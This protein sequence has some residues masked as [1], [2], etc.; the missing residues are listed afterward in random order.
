MIDALQISLKI[1]DDLKDKGWE[2]ALSGSSING[3]WI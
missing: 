3:M 2:I 1:K